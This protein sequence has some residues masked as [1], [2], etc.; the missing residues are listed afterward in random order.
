MALYPEQIPCENLGLKS[1]A[2]K[3]FGRHVLLGALDAQFPAS[4]DHDSAV[5]DR[6]SDYRSET[7]SSMPPP[8]HTTSQPNA[9]VHQFPMASRL[10]QQG[11]AREAGTEPTRGYEGDY[12]ERTAVRRYDSLDST[13]SGRS[14]LESASESS[15]MTSRRL[16]LE[17]RHS[18]E[19]PESRGPLASDGRV[20]IIPFDYEVGQDVY[21]D[22]YEDL[23]KQLIEDFLEKS[24]RTRSWQELDAR[25]SPPHSK[26]E[27]A[28]GHHERSRPLR[29]ARPGSDVPSYPEEYD[30]IDRRRKKKRRYNNFE[31]C[32][33]SRRRNDG[34]LR[35]AHETVSSLD[36]IETGSEPDVFPE[37]SETEKYSSSP[38]E[39]AEPLPVYP[40]LRPYKNGL[41]VKSGK[42]CNSRQTALDAGSVH[43]SREDGVLAE[44]PANCFV[45][46]GG[47]EEFDSSASDELQSSPVSED[48]DVEELAV[49]SQAWCESSICRLGEFPENQGGGAGSLLLKDKKPHRAREGKHGHLKPDL[50]LSPVEEPTE[51]YVDAM[52]ELQCLVETVSEYLAEK[53]E[54]ISKFGSLPKSKNES[55]LL[56]R[57]SADNLA[58]ENACSDQ[59]KPASAVEDREGGQGKPEALTDLFGV[60]NTV[61]SLFS[62]FTEKVGSGTKHL[63]ASVEKF[64]SLA[65]EKSETLGQSEGGMMKM[66]PGQSK[67]EGTAPEAK[68][69]NKGSVKVSAAV[70][71]LTQDSVKEGDPGTAIG[72]PEKADLGGMLNPLKIF[73]EKEV[74]KR[75]DVKQEE[76]VKMGDHHTSACEAKASEKLPEGHAKT[77]QGS[78]EPNRNEA[79]PRTGGGPVSSILDKLSSSVS[80][81]SLKA[82]FEHL[83]VPKQATAPPDSSDVLL[84]DKVLEACRGP[85]GN[86][87]LEGQWFE[88]KPGVSRKEAPAR[89]SEPGGSSENFFS[90]LKRSFSLLLLPSAESVPKEAPS[91]LKKSYQSEDDVRETGSAQSELHFPFTGKLQIPFFSS[92]GSSVKQEKEKQGFFASFSRAASAENL[93]DSKALPRQQGFS[94]MPMNAERGR[95]SRNMEPAKTV[96]SKPTSVPYGLDHQEGP[97]VMRETGEE[98]SPSAPERGDRHQI[99]SGSWAIAQAECED[100]ISVQGLECRR[101]PSPLPKEP[102]LSAANVMATSKEGK[103][104]D[105]SAKAAPQPGFFS[106]LFQHSSSDQTP[107]RQNLSVEN[108]TSSQK[109]SPPGLLSGLFRFA[110]SENVSDPKPEKVK[111]SPSGL[112]KFF[113]K[114]EESGSTD[115]SVDLHVAHCPQEGTGEKREVS[116]FAKNIVHKPRG[117]P[118][119]NAAESPKTG[120]HLPNMG[121]MKMDNDP[122]PFP[123]HSVSQHALSSQ[124]NMQDFSGRPPVYRQ[125]TDCDIYQMAVNERSN[126]FLN[127]SLLNAELYGQP[128]Q[129]CAFEETR[130]KSSFDWDY[131]ALEHP[132]N[133]QQVSFPVYYVLNQNLNPLDQLFDWSESSDTALNLCK[134]DRNANVVDWRSD[135]NFDTQSVDVSVASYESLDQLAF[136]DFCL[137]KG[138]MWANGSLNGSLPPFDDYALEEMPMDLSF[139]SAGD[140]SMW[141]LREQETLSMDGSFVY[142]SY[143]QEYQDWLMLLEYGVWWP[144]EDGDCG[145]YLYS[146]GQYVY[147][148][149]TDLTGQY[150]YVCTPDTYAYLDYW[151]YNYPGDF[152]GSVVLDDNTVAVCG[153]KVPLGSESELLWIAEEEQLDQ[154]HASKPLDLSVAFQRSDQLMNMNLETF[155]QMFEESIYYQREL[156]LDFSGYRLQKLKVDF[157]PERETELPLT[158]DLTVNSRVASSRRPEGELHPGQPER[159]PRTAASETG[160]SRRF[161]FHIFQS[162]AKSEPLSETQN[163]PDSG[164]AQE[165]RRAP[166]NKV[167]SLFST[168]GGLLG[169]TSGSDGQKAPDGVEAV[170]EFPGHAHDALPLTSPK[171]RDDADSRQQISIRCE[172]G[173]KDTAGFEML[174]PV[175]DDAPRGT[176]RKKAPLIRSPSQQSPGPTGGQPGQLEASVT[177]AQHRRQVGREEP[178]KTEPVPSQTSTEAEGTLFQSALK[179]FNRGEAPAPAA[180]AAAADKSQAAGFFD[181]FKAQLNKPSPDPPASLMRN[182]SERKTPAEKGEGLGIS[183]LF[184]SIGDLFRGDAAPTPPSA[185]V[186]PS[187]GT[188]AR[189]EREAPDGRGRQEPSDRAATPGPVAPLEQGGVE[190]AQ[191]RP[192]PEAERSTEK[193]ERM[194][195]LPSDAGHGPSLPTGPGMG[196]PSPPRGPRASGPAA[197][198]GGSHPG[199]TPVPAQP[200]GTKQEPG[201]SWP[202]GLSQAADPSKP[203]SAGKSFFS[204]FSAEEAPPPSSATQDA[205]PAEAEGLFK[206]PSFL[207]GGG[208][209]AKKN[210]PQSSSSF[211]FFSL[212]S[213]LDE[214]PPAAPAEPPPQQA[215]ARPSVKPSASVHSGIGVG[216]QQPRQEEEEATDVVA[217][218]LGKKEAVGPPSRAGARNVPAAELRAPGGRHRAGT[219]PMV[220]MDAS[221]ED[222]KSASLGPK[223]QEDGGALPEPVEQPPKSMGEGADLVQ[224]SE[225][226][227]ALLYGEENTECLPVLDTGVAGVLLQ[228]GAHEGQPDV[229][230]LRLREAR[231]AADPHLS[232]ADLQQTPAERAR[233]PMPAAPALQDAHPEPEGDRSVLDAS[234]EMFSSFVTKMKPTKTFSDF[235]SQPQAPAAPSAQRKSSSFFGFSSLPSGPP[236]AFTGDFF[237]IF[238]GAS[239]EAPPAAPKPP[240]ADSHAKE[241]AGNILRRSAT[242]QEQISRAELLGTDGSG[243]FER[244]GAS[245]LAED[246]TPKEWAVR[247]EREASKRPESSQEEPVVDAPETG[248]SREDRGPE[249]AP[250]EACLVQS[251]L[252]GDAGPCGQ[253]AEHA[254]GPEA[255]E[256]CLRP[257]EMGVASAAEEPKVPEQEIEAG[258][259]DLGGAHELEPE[260]GEVAEGSCQSPTEAEAGTKSGSPGASEPELVSDE[261]QDLPQEGPARSLGAEGEAQREKEEPPAISR[262]AAEAAPWAQA[263]TE[264]SSARPGFELPSM[265]GLP[266][267]SFA[268]STDGGKPFGSFF[269]LQP[270]AASQAPAEPGL[271]SGL[272]KFSSTL[273][274]GGS[275]EKAGKPEGAPPGTAFGVKLDFSFPWQKETRPAPPQE[276]AGPPPAG[277]FPNKDGA[278]RASPGPEVPAPQTAPAPEQPV[279]LGINTEASAKA[280]EAGQP[281]APAAK[282]DSCSEKSHRF[283]E[284]SSGPPAAVPVPSSEEVEGARLGDSED[285]PGT[286]V[287]SG[288]P[289]PALEEPAEGAEPEETFPP[290]AT[291]TPPPGLQPLEPTSSRPREEERRPVARA[292]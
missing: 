40:V 288:P 201:W 103:V 213:F 61:S 81:F 39:R 137:E 239:E 287:P 209:A 184:G 221:R 276:G 122:L 158:L 108:D 181:F 155:S 8:Y 55:F 28:K 56:K 11:V 110:S 44:Q 265:L 34:S 149:L 95:K 229:P 124:Q 177:P 260:A 235:F 20:R 227:A 99:A 35:L 22:H 1:S 263:S 47:L 49:L 157:T 244:G 203:Q 147:S 280:P 248:V 80:S 175:R 104:P 106:G 59:A 189:V 12:R 246:A 91:G 53:E 72:A 3:A 82:S 211:S 217:A 202:F 101:A 167:T 291:G 245:V 32:E 46:L 207:S 100:N 258:P 270:P 232:H 123:W 230:E 130:R 204:F 271:M 220:V 160:P 107:S 14:D 187:G 283:G 164:R 279:P 30:T 281:P 200:I 236:Q 114:G 269:T 144:S 138:E 179:I 286:A 36:T 262:A 255:A 171:K 150:V 172:V 289:S 151:D 126:G 247:P 156:P 199:A 7:S 133:P 285:E 251:H 83:A 119:E 90:P 89:P 196:H 111:T 198:P 64:V 264:S 261:E 76:V 252:V 185:P 215:S 224:P 195:D 249:A 68:K 140:G 183:S 228:G 67:S 154:D 176:Q 182:E 43:L 73:S 136:E 139:S 256:V 268:P 273:F 240:S 113:T 284:G 54:E 65:P 205:R 118:E 259:V 115:K 69:D 173:R 206:L 292:A 146:D 208:P 29:T 109:R 4:E 266:K 141:P 243:V 48:D 94:G 290:P 13:L 186:L 74:P 278:P 219:P 10:Q 237:G 135:A 78:A 241:A 27:I 168:L 17:S 162:P 58:E 70:A 174:G 242:K 52:G 98:D 191:R 274:G 234:V 170:P 45:P 222:Q 41:L 25:K 163:E 26:R 2:D 62:S 120:G 152:L 51:E 132:E 253:D 143:S 134:K 92:F 96:S 117:K 18:L 79:E 180:A 131:N 250:W 142:P 71:S 275:E 33:L 218:V 238:K 282:S 16:S 165:D 272:H 77:T 169:K 93:T 15:Q 254:A 88:N 75:E 23:G 194:D 24:Q 231:G 127:S 105:A 37:Y 223:P 19:L 161:S 66:F 116:N 166:V 193:G 86:Q 216:S 84:P 212:T 210:V 128:G 277:G 21:P 9:S 60:K 197:S 5:E 129:Y 192:L 6:D 112:M 87:Q 63:S 226:T 178:K 214:A 233:P 257:L 225:K 125:H 97:M 42:L 145:Y 57:A 188:Q 85:S 121:L 148:L 267:L 50:A 102:G 153:F 31:E 38:M 190:T 159:T